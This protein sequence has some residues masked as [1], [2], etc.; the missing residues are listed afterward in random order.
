MS[1]S[2]SSAVIP[3]TYS[4]AIRQIGT[5]GIKRVGNLVLEEFVTGLQGN[6]GRARYREMAMNDPTVKRGLRAIKWQMLKPEWRVEGAEGP[7]A[8]KAETFLLSCI[9]DMSDTWREALREVFTCLDYG[10]SYAQILYKQCVGPD[11][12]DPTKRSQYKDNLVRWRKWSF[13]GQETW[14]GWHFDE[15]G[16]MDG[17]YQTDLYAPQQA[18]RVLIPLNGS[19]TDNNETVTA[20]SLHFKVEGRLG[21]P[22]GE[23]VL[24]SAYR[25]WSFKKEHELFEAIRSERDATGIPV[26]EVQEGGP[27]LWDTTDAVATA[28]R[29]YL[30]KA[31]TALRLDDQTCI[32]VPPGIVFRLERS[33]GA[34]QIDPDKTIRRLDWQI[35]GALLAQFLELGQAAHGSFAKSESD[36]DLFISAMEGILNHT[37]AETIN[38]FEVPRL[39]RLNEGSFRLKKLPRFVPGELQLDTLGDMADPLGKLVSSGLLTP[40]ETL[41]AWLR[42]RGKMPKAD[43][44]TAVVAEPAVPPT[45]SAP[46][47][48]AGASGTATPSTAPAATGPVLAS[49]LGKRRSFHDLMHKGDRT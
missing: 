37:I 28:L 9:E 41:E 11:Q 29:G 39:F 6:Q 42:Q 26:F 14:D 16:D 43:P 2:T 31:G 45:T 15:H 4:N 21:D 34:P 19:I 17:L 32:I 5:P 44:A 27:N 49:T 1:A 23:S 7:D 24:R 3:L 10:A 20:Y 38:R 8:E 48:A 46:G 47:V 36:Q 30:E 22:E 35:L 12:K 18:S 13:R 40:D 33:P 25:P